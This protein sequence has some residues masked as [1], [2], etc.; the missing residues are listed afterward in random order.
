MN[1]N[2]AELIMGLDDTTAGFSKDFDEMRNKSSMEKFV[3]IFS[4]GKAESM[5]QERMRSAS[6]DEK[7]QDLIAKSDIIVKLLD[8]QLQEL[9]SQQEKVQ[10]N[11]ERLLGDREAAVAELESLRAEIEAL[12][13]QLIDL[14]SKIS[15]EQDAAQRT[16]LE[17]E[18]A[19]TNTRYNTYTNIR[20]E[21]TREHI[22]AHT[23][24]QP[25]HTKSPARTHNHIY[26]H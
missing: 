3:G 7:L 2:I 18:L 1:A 10:K 4:K 22:T 11:L 17:T 24:K 20:H 26:K 13:P 25:L 16:R 12:D 15:V 23:P 9:E 14:E 19:D 5:R 8:G 6:I 21:D